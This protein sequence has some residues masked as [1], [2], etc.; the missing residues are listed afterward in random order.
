MPGVGHGVTIGKLIEYALA[1]RRWGKLIA[2]G[3]TAIQTEKACGFVA[4][5]TL[6]PENLDET[7]RRSQH[8]SDKGGEI[9]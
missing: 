6:L 3:G 8:F 4:G 1:F 2:A 7:S 5:E 9:Q